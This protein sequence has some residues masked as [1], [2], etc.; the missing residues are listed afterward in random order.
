[1]KKRIVLSTVGLIL[2]AAGCGNGGSTEAG[3]NSTIVAAFYPLAFA[4]ERVGG[5]EPEVRNLTPPGVE[6]HDL[7]LSARDVRTVADADLVLYLG[8]GFQPAIEDVLAST[9]ARAVDLLDGLELLE[10]AEE[11]GS[12]GGGRDPHVW[13][14]PLRY[15][16]IA[17][18]L[19]EELDRPEAAGD[20]AAALRALD[21]EFQAGLADC[22]RRELV[23]S[24]A[25]FGYLAERYD[26]AQVALSG[27]EPEAEPTPRELEQVV[28]EVRAHGA[29][30]I[31]FETLVSPRLA[32]TVAREVGARTST[33]NPLEGL[34]PEEI[35]DGAD[36]FSVMRANL[37]AL[38]EA[39]ECR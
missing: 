18:R 4:A 6:P 27:L 31:F 26:L 9:D 30:T 20:L 21:G 38:R 36:Y 23:T 12:E 39:L 28:Q 33:L 8:Q 16:A 24:H 22:E 10:D 13:L 37:A 32:Q 15:A 19:G 35:D 7:E 25:A 11:Q 14:D 5:G 17:E 2:T 29:T 1:M 3:S 34:T